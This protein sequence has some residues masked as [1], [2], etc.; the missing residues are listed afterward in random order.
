VLNTAMAGGIYQ[1]VTIIVLKIKE[2]K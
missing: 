1:P 2:L